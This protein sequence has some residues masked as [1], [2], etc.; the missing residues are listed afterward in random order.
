M[1]RNKHYDLLNLIGYGLARFDTPYNTPFVRALGFKTNNALY[2]HL[3]S[4]Q[5]A[6]SPGSIKNYRDILD[7]FFPD[8]GRAGWWQSGNT[9]QHRKV[10]VERTYDDLDPQR[11]AAL[12]MRQI[13]NFGR[14]IDASYD[15]PVW[16]S[17]FRKLRHPSYGAENY[18]MTNFEIVSQFKGG[19]LEDARGLGD[20]YDF[21][22]KSPGDKYFLAEVKGMRMQRGQIRLTE[23]EYKKAKEFKSDYGL[24]VV[25]NLEENPQMTPIFDPIKNLG[26][27]P[28]EVQ[29]SQMEYHTE[30]LGK[31]ALEQAA[32]RR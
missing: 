10:I 29:S 18:F 25:R 7:P 24:I 15:V 21:Q 16:D 17:K 8:N 14:Q 9:Y 13:P 28:K 30:I 3:V 12:V 19:N 5:I 23:S 31:K 27:I 20:G 2:D 32:A 22:I 1:P 11:L 26:L 6:P 4:L